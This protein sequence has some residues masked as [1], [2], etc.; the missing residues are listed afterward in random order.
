MD[1]ETLNALDSLFSNIESQRE[2]LK[3]QFYPSYKKS[4]LEFSVY[5][6]ADIAG[7][8]IFDDHPKKFGITKKQAQ[9]VREYFQTTNPLENAINELYELFPDFLHGEPIFKLKSPSTLNK[10]I[11][12]YAEEEI[13][14]VN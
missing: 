6:L 10:Y 9:L 11:P 7:N 4:P 3:E 1:K 12:W 13:A 14:R 8:H 2:F 5:E